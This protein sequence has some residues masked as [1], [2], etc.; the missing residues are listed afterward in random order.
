MAAMAAAEEFHH[1]S[2]TPDPIM[3]RDE[4]SRSGL[5]PHSDEESRAYIFAVCIFYSAS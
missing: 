3:P 4:I 5:S 1:T 2:S